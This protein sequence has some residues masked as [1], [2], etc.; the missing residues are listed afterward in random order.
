M[1]IRRAI[2]KW[3]VINVLS[4]LGAL[5]SSCSLR[6]GK[7]EGGASQIRVTVWEAVSKR[8][9][10]NKTPTNS[11]PGALNISRSR[12]MYFHIT[13][14]HPSLFKREVQLKNT[15]WVLLI[16]KQKKWKIHI[17]TIIEVNIWRRGGKKRSEYLLFLNAD[18]CTVSL[19]QLSSSCFI[20]H[21][22]HSL[23]IF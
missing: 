8:K 23:E 5:V 15:H 14:I 20:D 3:R 9:I 17:Y 13:L 11:F 22:A 6:G 2:C 18:E 10:N 7:A 4:K 21:V 1:D 19:K 12:L 16:S